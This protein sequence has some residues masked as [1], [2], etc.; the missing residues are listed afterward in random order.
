LPVP[1]QPFPAPPISGAPDRSAAAHVRAAV[2]AVPPRAPFPPAGRHGAHLQA[3]PA[4]ASGRPPAAHVQAALGAGVQAKPD[5]GRSSAGRPVAPHVQAAVVQARAAAVSSRAPGVVSRPAPSRLAPPAL[6]PLPPPAVRSPAATGPL[7]SATLQGMFTVQ[8]G[9]KDG[10]EE[11]RINRNLLPPIKQRNKKTLKGLVGTQ[12][13]KGLQLAFSKKKL[14][15][16][17]LEEVD[18]IRVLEKVNEW[19]QSKEEVGPFETWDEVVNAAVKALGL[20]AKGEK[21]ENEKGPRKKKGS[22]CPAEFLEDPDIVKVINLLSIKEGSCPLLFKVFLSLANLYEELVGGGHFNCRRL[23]KVTCVNVSIHGGESTGKL[24]T[25]GHLT[26]S[27]CVEIQLWKGPIEQIIA[28]GKKVAS[29]LELDVVVLLDN[30]VSRIIGGSVQIGKLNRMTVHMT[31]ILEIMTELRRLRFEERIT[32]QAGNRIGEQFIKIFWGVEEK[33]QTKMCRELWAAIGVLKNNPGLTMT[34]YEKKWMHES[35]DYEFD[36]VFT[37]FLPEKEKF[38]VELESEKEGTKNK[39]DETAVAYYGDRW[40]KKHKN[41]LI[42]SKNY[43][44]VFLLSPHESMPKDFL[45]KIESYAL[46]KQGVKLQI[47]LPSLKFHGS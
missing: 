5:P 28:V 27:C 16:L 38:V 18:A 37:C 6:P 10:D 35:V 40:V 7:G 2:G 19:A 45:E 30:L 15:A 43:K 29:L 8:K 47:T 22:D 33:N 17:G 39:W 23:R 14:E 12:L 42:L 41:F 9:G 32:K 26:K 44:I 3:A 46:K 36:L 21:E 11:E 31:N 24:A 4:P 20:G 34:Y 13:P 1:R 25:L